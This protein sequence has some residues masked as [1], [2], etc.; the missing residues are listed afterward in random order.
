MKKYIKRFNDF[1]MFKNIKIVFEYIN[2]LFK[3][4]GLFAHIII[5]IFLT[6]ILTMILLFEYLKYGEIK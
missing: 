5:A 3:E 6:P 2:I 1:E 4:Q